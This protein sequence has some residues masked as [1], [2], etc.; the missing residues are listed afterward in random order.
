M[1][2]QHARFFALVNVAVFFTANPTFAQDYWNDRIQPDNTLTVSHNTNIQIAKAV[3]EAE[4]SSV[5][6]ERTEPSIAI[7]P[8]NS[9]NLLVV[10]MT[11]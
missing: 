3:E 4:G 1:K 9:S 5:D 11:E 7:D 2:H 6:F 8:T 10:A